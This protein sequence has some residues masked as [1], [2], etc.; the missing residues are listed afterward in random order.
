VPRTELRLFKDERG[1]V[2]I[3]EWF[4]TIQARNRK[5]A[6]K[7]IARITMLRDSGH[8]LRRPAASPLRDG[9]YELRWDTG[10]VNYRILYGYIG[11]NLAVL[12]HCITKEAE[13]PANEI[14]RAARRLQLAAADPDKYTVS[15]E[16]LL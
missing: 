11:K 13:V 15:T 6:A 12:S 10:N 8:E 2:P 14:D 7:A 1:R 16:D 4:E 9:V 3:L 5:V